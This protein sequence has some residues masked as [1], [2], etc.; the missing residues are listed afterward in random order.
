MSLKG[1]REEQSK[2]LPCMCVW[3]VSVDGDASVGSQAG[4]QRKERSLELREDYGK[5]YRGTKMFSL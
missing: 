2:I 5:D 1:H 4:G 3:Q